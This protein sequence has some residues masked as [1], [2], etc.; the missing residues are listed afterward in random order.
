[1]NDDENRPELVPAGYVLVDVVLTTHQAFIVRKW[2]AAAQLKIEA[3]RAATAK[4]RF[5]ARNEVEDFRPGVRCEIVSVHHPCF[6][7]DVGKVIVVTKVSAD[8][9]QVWAHDDRPVTYKINRNGRRVVDSD[10]RCIQTVY[11]MDGLRVL[12]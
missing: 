12:E 7:R 9:R 4:P 8:T 1:M 11:G 6:S 5:D 3:A 2:E 10:P